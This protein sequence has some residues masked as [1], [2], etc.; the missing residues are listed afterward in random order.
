L[1]RPIDVREGGVVV[2][3]N[4]L[5]IGPEVFSV[6]AGTIV[7]LG[8]A[9]AFAFK[10]R[11]TSA[12]AG[13]HGQRPQGQAAEG[14]RVSPDGFIDS[15]AGVISEA[16]GGLPFTAWLIIGVTLVCY[17]VYLFVNWN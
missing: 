3:D 1:A 9:L 17:V 8:A 4:V 7:F 16:G 15:F 10:Y 14:E 13:E 2:P 11:A 12:K 5:R 6:V